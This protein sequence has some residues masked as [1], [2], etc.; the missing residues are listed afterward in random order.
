MT[1]LQARRAGQFVTD[2]D[3]VRGHPFSVKVPVSC[4]ASKFSVGAGPQ[5]SAGHPAPHS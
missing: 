5:P 4:S 2:G 3:H 1:T